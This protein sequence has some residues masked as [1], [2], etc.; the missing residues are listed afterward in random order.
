MTLL[1]FV[2]GCESVTPTPNS[3]V[4][5]ATREDRANHAAALA[6]DPNDAAVITGQA[7]IARLDAA[8]R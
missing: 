5:D 7:L 6:E 4:C 8:C 2:T 3:A 1:F